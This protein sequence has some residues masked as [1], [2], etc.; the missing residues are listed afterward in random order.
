MSLFTQIRKYAKTALLG[1]EK[2]ERL[3]PPWGLD[4][5][6]CSP[7]AGG[8]AVSFYSNVDPQSTRGWVGTSGSPAT[9]QEPRPRYCLEFL[10]PLASQLLLSFLYFLSFF[11]F[12]SCYRRNVDKS[13][14]LSAFRFFFLFFFFLFR[15]A[16]AAYG[17]SQVRVELELQLQ[18]YTTATETQDLSRVCDL[19]HSSQQHQ[20][21]NPLS[22]AKDQTCILMDTSW[23]RYH[24]A[25]M[26]IP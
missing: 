15:A 20:P 6:L 16:M 11:F 9:A 7:R 25:T 1:A 4:P 14:A 22:K 19:H 21:L 3:S 24:W 2:K 8:S 18:A 23:V 12:F 5:A 17:S 13:I 26:G 10:L